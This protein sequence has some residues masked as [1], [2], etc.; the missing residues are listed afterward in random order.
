MNC[1]DCGTRYSDGMC[2][3]CH[4]ELFILVTQAEDLDDVRL[5]DEFL[6]KAKE[7]ADV[8]SLQERR[9]RA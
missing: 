7:Q 9:K 6:A 5:S 2:P 1:E 8:L 3:N 4:E